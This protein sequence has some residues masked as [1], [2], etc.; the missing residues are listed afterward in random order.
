[1]DEA[2]RDADVVIPKSWGCLDTM[3][4]NPAESLRIAK[5]YT[6]WICNRERMALARP[7]CSTCIRSP[8]IAATK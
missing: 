5:Q 8:P 3:G 1:M 4:S 6:S 7:E 2:F